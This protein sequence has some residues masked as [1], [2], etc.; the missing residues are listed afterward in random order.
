ML[1]ELD[2]MVGFRVAPGETDPRG[3]TVVAC[4]GAA[5][6]VVRTLLIDTELLKAR[7]LVTQLESNRLVVLPVVLARFDSP[8]RRVIYDAAEADCIAR[9]PDYA[10]LPT[11]VDADLIQM[12][13][14]GDSSVLPN[15]NGSP[16]RRR[17][18]RRG[19]T[20]A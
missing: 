5:V 16:D 14:I 10:G 18:S 4:N 3:W 12:T 8:A 1:A 11:A 20:N 7:Y 13:L 15:P 6:G 2:S 17:Y 9:L 19:S